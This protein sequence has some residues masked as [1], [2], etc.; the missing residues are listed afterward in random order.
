[1]KMRHE[2]EVDWPHLVEIVKV[3]GARQVEARLELG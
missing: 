2:D 3:V 1:M